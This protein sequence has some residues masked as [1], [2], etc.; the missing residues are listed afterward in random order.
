VPVFLKVALRKLQIRASRGRPIWWTAFCLYMAVLATSSFF[1]D[2]GLFTSYRLWTEEK[3]LDRDISKLDSEVSTL[4]EEVRGFR[5][6]PRAVER[7][8]RE[9]LQLVGKNEIQYIFR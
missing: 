1:S 6:D 8:A 2:R 3:R 5:T 9:E 7:Y 4:R